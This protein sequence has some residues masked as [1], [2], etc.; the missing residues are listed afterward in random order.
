MQKSKKRKD[1]QVEKK[2]LK[3]SNNKDQTKLIRNRFRLFYIKSRLN[4]Q[5]EKFGRHFLKVVK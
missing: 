1:E 3:D 4:D 2:N 5:Q